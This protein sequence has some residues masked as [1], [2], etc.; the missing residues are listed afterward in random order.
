MSSGFNYAGRK[1]IGLPALGPTTLAAS[2]PWQEEDLVD[3]PVINLVL[4]QGFKLA[5]AA[6]AI[7]SSTSLLFSALTLSTSSHTN[8][9]LKVLEVADIRLSIDTCP[10]KA[11]WTLL[12][13]DVF[14][15]VAEQA[16]KV[17]VSMEKLN[18]GRPPLACH[19]LP[20]MNPL[21]Y[22]HCVVSAFPIS[23]VWNLYRFVE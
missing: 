12:P 10:E 18:V 6:G 8:I 19:L 13:G 11:H 9:Q 17:K 22:Q 4:S 23:Q 14:M 15:G 3:G 7:R 2:M 1:F 21:N 5:C 20:K 16:L